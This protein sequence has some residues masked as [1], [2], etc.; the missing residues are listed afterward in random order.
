MAE[1]LKGTV[2]WFNN[3]KGYGFIEGNDGN[4]YFVH[5]KYIM[6]DGFKQL[7]EGQQVSFTAGESQKGNGKIAIE[8]EV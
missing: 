7:T 4:E 8:V 5:Y 6:G 3:T 2:K 1:R